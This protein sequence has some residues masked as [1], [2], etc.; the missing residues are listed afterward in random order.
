MPE[1]LLGELAEVKFF[2]LLKPL[3]TGKKTGILTIQGKEDG[4]IFLEAGNIVHAKTGHSFGEEAFLSIMGWTAGK[5]TFEPDVPPRDRTISIPTE[6]LLLNWSYRK[7]E[8]E[9]IRKV[10]HSPNDIFR[11]SLQNDIKDKNVKGDQWNVLALT[12][13]SRT[14]S[15]IARS[16]GWDEFKTSKAIYRLIQAGFV[17]RTEE[18]RFSN[19]KAIGENFFQMLEHEL[20]KVMGPVAP[21]I[22]DDKLTDFGESKE[23]LPLDQALSFV[24]AVR[25]E[26]PNEQRREE[27]K[28]EMMGFLSSGIRG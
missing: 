8:W 17:E 12:N 27:F 13:G 6:N 18:R 25:E 3:L 4:E 22:I 9:R 1:T 11:I 23:S 20:K 21:F 7:Q 24:E 15:E 26:I 19:R 28:R 14:I 2:D 10:I 16:L 5:A